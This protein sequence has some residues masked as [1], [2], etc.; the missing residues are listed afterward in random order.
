MHSVSAILLASCAFVLTIRLYIFLLL[1]MYMVVETFPVTVT[2]QISMG[3]AASQTTQDLLLRTRL[4][5][6][7]TLPASFQYNRSAS[8]SYQF[9]IR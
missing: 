1:V 5:L 9:F 3:I 2:A 7:P 6:A 8:K 4:G